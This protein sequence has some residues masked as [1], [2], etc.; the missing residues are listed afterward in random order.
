MFK[1]EAD[2]AIKTIVD[3]ML[4]KF[5]GPELGLIVTIDCRVVDRQDLAGPYESEH[6][7][8][9][10][11]FSRPDNYTTVWYDVIGKPSRSPE[12]KY[13]IDHDSCWKDV[14]RDTINKV[15]FEMCESVNPN[16]APVS[17]QNNCW[18]FR[19]PKLVKIKTESV[20]FSNKHKSSIKKVLSVL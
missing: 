5:S 9:L 20:L 17:L 7:E 13:L 1:I 15:Y 19:A 18:F 11:L 2:A 4:P 6:K 14:M 16:V 3:G 10:F 12:W 8:I